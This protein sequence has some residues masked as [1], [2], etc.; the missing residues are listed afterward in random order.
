MT[1]DG[2]I[3]NS[4]NPDLVLS[5]AVDPTSTLQAPVYDTKL[6][7]AFK[8][9]VPY[10]GQL[11]T[12]T[13]GGI[14]YSRQNGLVLTVNGTFD[15]KTGTPVPVFVAPL[16]NPA[17]PPPSQVWDFGTGKGLQAVLAQPPQP[18][19]Y[20]EDDRS[21]YKYIDSR[22]GLSNSTLRAEYLN[23]AAPLA[24]YQTLLSRMPPPEQYRTKPTIP[25]WEAIIGQLEQELTAAVAVQ[26]L[27]QQI[28]DLHINLGL[29]Q[30]MALQELATLLAIPTST[31]VPPSRRKARPGSGTLSRVSPIR[32]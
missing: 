27:F 25:E 18:F 30:T 8:A 26:A 4:L 7:I 20:P 10:A 1:A 14:I 21:A 17:S 13:A 15:P 5:L 16:A 22:L 12:A 2:Y 11:W 28:T 24:S 9:P 29:Q 31:P 32:P 3:V 6:V 19:P 23:L